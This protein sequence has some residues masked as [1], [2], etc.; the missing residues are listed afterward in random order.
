M[1]NANR[2]VSAATDSPQKACSVRPMDIGSQGNILKMPVSI[3]LQTDCF[4]ATK[5]TTTG[6]LTHS[7]FYSLATRR[8]NLSASI[9][10]I[11]P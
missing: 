9:L 1:T 11:A 8:I 10:D 3:G 2:F 5:S 6:N 4:L 7:T